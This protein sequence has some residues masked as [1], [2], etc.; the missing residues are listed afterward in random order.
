VAPAQRTDDPETNNTVK[1]RRFDYQQTPRRRAP[2][3][4]AIPDKAR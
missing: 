2:G 4:N 3:A 1:S